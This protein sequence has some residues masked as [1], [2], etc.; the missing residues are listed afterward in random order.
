MSNQPPILSQCYD[1]LKSSMEI[2]RRFPRDHKFLLGA[3]IQNLISDLLENY[4]DAYYTANGSRKRTKLQEANLQ[5]E[6]LRFFFRLAFDLRLISAG[7]YREIAE[8]IQ[9]LGKMTGG[10]LKRIKA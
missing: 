7:L 3:R 4:I 6:K 1:L 8:N 5:L 9:T 10:W 2:I